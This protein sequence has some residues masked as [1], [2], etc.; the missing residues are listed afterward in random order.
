MILFTVE[1][2]TSHVYEAMLKKD[3]RGHPVINP[4]ISRL[5]PV[6]VSGQQVV[7]VKGRVFGDHEAGS[8]GSGVKPA[9]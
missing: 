5:L 9:L 6:L 3:E 8:R 1:Q 4:F 2:K 7:G